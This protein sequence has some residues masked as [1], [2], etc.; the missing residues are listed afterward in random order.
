MID[1]SI[2]LPQAVVKVLKDSGTGPIKNFTEKNHGGCKK[3]EFLKKFFIIVSGGD[4]FPLL[5]T[6]TEP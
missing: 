1:Y 6:R 2:G 3:I 4:E 5:C